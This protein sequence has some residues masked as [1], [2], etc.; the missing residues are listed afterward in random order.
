MGRNRIYFGCL[1][2]AMFAM[3]AYASYGMLNRDQPE[4][5][6]PISV[7]VD[8]SSS[9]RWFAFREGLKQAARDYH[10]QLNIVSTGELST[11]ADEKA[12]IEREKENG[13]KGIIIQMC[14]SEDEQAYAQMQEAAGIVDILLV[15]TDMEPEGVFSAVIPDNREMGRMIAVSLREDEKNLEGKKI[16][17]LS[18]NRERLSQKQRLDGFLEAMEG[19]GAQILWEIGNHEIM[20][21]ALTKEQLQ[22]V[23]IL[24]ALEN[25][26]TER[27][28]D[29]LL[30][31]DTPLCPLYGVGSSEKNVY[32]LDKK[33]IEVLIVPNEFH[34]GYESVAVMAAQL[35]EHITPQHNELVSFLVVR[36][37]TMYEEDN[38][39]LLFPLVQ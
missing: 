35:Q 20:Q 24:V 9:D 18:G 38:Q 34:M 33:L 25:D 7:I 22:H 1:I 30:E 31:P 23:E 19:S 28:V 11:L 5:L 13:A 26:E 21:T 32:Y 4:K 10:V 15:E 8:N 6:Y 2:A 37:E 27:A 17:I 12:L 14:D 29:Y 3:I 36:P 16:G 39:K